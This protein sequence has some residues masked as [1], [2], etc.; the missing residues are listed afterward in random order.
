MRPRELFARILITCNGKKLFTKERENSLAGEEG[1]DVKEGVS[2]EE[3]AD[4]G[5]VESGPNREEKRS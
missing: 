4:P 3:A 1:K 5:G 2:A